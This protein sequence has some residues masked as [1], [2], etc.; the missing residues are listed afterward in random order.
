MGF[1]NYKFS[2]LPS[3]LSDYKENKI[4]DEEN[5]LII[6]NILNYDDAPEQ[7]LRIIKSAYKRG[8]FE[9]KNSKLNNI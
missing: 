3:N 4:V 8:Y 9:G 1:N 7:L 2:R 6:R 5:L